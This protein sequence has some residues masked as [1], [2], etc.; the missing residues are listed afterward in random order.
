VT[1]PVYGDTLLVAVT[2]TRCPQGFGRT[3]DFAHFQQVCSHRSSIAA[4]T[5]APP[6][7]PSPANR[8]GRWDAPPAAA[9]LPPPWLLGEPG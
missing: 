8:L 7:P 2:G 1:P 5:A 4:F 3:L 6:L 9:T